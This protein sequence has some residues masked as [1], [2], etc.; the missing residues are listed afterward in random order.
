MEIKTIRVVDNNKALRI[1]LDAFFEGIKRLFVLAFVDI[2]NGAKKVERTNHQKYFLHRVNTSNYN[3]LMMAELFMINLLANNSKN[4][5]KLERFQQG[6]NM[7]TQQDVC[8]NINTLKTIINW[9]RLILA[10][11]K[12]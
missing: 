3:V 4:M 11:R 1:M 8:W 9:L 10:S 5:M 12:N 6:K 2:A 7:I